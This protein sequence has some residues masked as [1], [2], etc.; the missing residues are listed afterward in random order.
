MLMIQGKNFR[1]AASID[2]SM[3]SVEAAL[4]LEEAKNSPQSKSEAVPFPSSLQSVPISADVQNQR[5]LDDE[6][7]SIPEPENVVPADKIEQENQKV[8]IPF[9]SVT[10]EDLLQARAE[11]RSKLMEQMTA[12]CE[13]AKRTQCYDAL[14]DRV[15]ALPEAPPIPFDLL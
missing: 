6:S 3:E 4:C 14:K 2:A 8:V 5:I 7:A 1:S 12:C 10:E 11:Q 15:F 13:E 9:D